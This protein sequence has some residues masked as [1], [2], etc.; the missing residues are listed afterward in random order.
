MNEQCNNKQVLVCVATPS[1]TPY[2]D[3]PQIWDDC[4]CGRYYFLKVILL[5]P[6][7]HDE[8]YSNIDSGQWK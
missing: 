8:D 3:S 5:L 4:R 6:S 1:P 7:S 2:E